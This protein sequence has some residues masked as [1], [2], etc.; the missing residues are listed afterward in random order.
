MKW[1]AVNIGN[2]RQHWGWFVDDTLLE[3]SDH[4]LD[5]WNAQALAQ[6]ERITVASVVPALVPR[7][8][9]L[10]QARIL[11]IAQIP[12]TNHYATLGVDRALNLVG[13]AYRYGQPVLVCD[14]G[15]AITLS[16]MDTDGAFGGGC[17]LP[18]LR[19]QFRALKS[20]T[21]ALPEV[22]LPEELPA[23]WAQ[24]TEQ[25][26]QAGVLQVTLA[27]I[28]QVVSGWRSQH[29]AAI[30]VATGGDSA[31][32]CRWYPH[33]FNV[34]DPHLTLWGICAV[35]QSRTD[36]DRSTEPSTPLCG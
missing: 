23:L 36:L 34:Q 31:R 17:I 21:A 29:S 32:V 22:E 13:A 20:Q 35:T 15:T 2:T 25:A 33:L 3:T 12:L 6:A 26:I 5:Y 8:Q 19:A 11:D 16:A 9:E 14:L 7:W 24:S 18:G 4:D 30:V 28:G 10:P 27:G 1:L